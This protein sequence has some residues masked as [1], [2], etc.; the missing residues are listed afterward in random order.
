MAL[1]S[2]LSLPSCVPYVLWFGGGKTIVYLATV[3][4]VAAIVALPS[5]EPLHNGS[6]TLLIVA[7][8]A[9]G[10]VIVTVSVAVQAFRS[11]TVTV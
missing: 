2:N 10:A 9:V 11:L 5:V 3:P 1:A 7:V 6:I 4:P 8:I